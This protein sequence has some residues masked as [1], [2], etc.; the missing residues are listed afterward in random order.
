MCIVVYNEYRWNC[1]SVQ[2]FIMIVGGIVCAF[3]SL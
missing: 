1:G 3:I 2:Y